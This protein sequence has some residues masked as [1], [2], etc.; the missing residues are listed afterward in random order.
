MPTPTEHV[1]QDVFKKIDRKGEGVIT[2]DLI[3]ASIKVEPGLGKTNVVSRKRIAEKIV[4]IFSRTPNRT[5]EITL[6][7][8]GEIRKRL[9]EFSKVHIRRLMAQFGLKMKAYYRL[10]EVEEEAGEEMDR[11]FVSKEDETNVGLG[12]SVNDATEMS[13]SVT[14]SNTTPV[15][16]HTEDRW[17][18]LFDDASGSPY[19]YNEATGETSWEHPSAISA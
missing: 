5:G 16:P 9:P 18:E 10:D 12:A 4:H 13:A 8:W 3:E 2:V 7:D 19:Y 1:W 17:V 15:P 6:D 11:S 14:T